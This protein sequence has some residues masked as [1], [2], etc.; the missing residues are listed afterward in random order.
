MIQLDSQF[1]QKKSVFLG[2]KKKEK[3]TYYFK[4]STTSINS[5]LKKIYISSWIWGTRYMV[6]SKNCA[7]RTIHVQY[8]LPIHWKKHDSHIHLYLP[9]YNF[10]LRKDFGLKK[11]CERKTFI[12]KANYLILLQNT[13]AM[14]WLVWKNSG[15]KM[16]CDNV[17]QE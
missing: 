7:L 10:S 1:F 15:V 17:P 2:K 8:P 16:Q 5:Q 13:T 3:E 6:W 12:F 4:L 9:V 14:L 11:R